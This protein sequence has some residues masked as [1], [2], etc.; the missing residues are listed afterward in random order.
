MYALIIIALFVPIF[1]E[2]IHIIAYIIYRIYIYILSS[3]AR[4]PPSSQA[5]N[6][7]SGCGNRVRN[8][9][10]QVTL[11]SRSKKHNFVIKIQI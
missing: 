2:G 11:L 7:T 4:L 10:K 1:F 5:G 6:E 8:L 3:Q 9:D